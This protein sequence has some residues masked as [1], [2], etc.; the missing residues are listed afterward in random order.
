ML[1]KLKSIKTEGYFEV[2][3]LFHF[4]QNKSSCVNVA[5]YN[6]ANR[7]VC[8]ISVRTTHADE[9]HKPSN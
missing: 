1:I 5:S 7:F 8:L 9:Y 3:K 4:L 6:K 2:K